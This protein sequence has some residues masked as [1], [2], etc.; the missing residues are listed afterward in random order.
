M[1]QL[2][3]HTARRTV[4]EA[5][6]RQI[7]ESPVRTSVLLLAFFGILFLHGPVVLLHPGLWGEDGWLWYPDAY[8]YGIKSLL[9]PDG[10]YLNTLSR[11]TA[12]VVQP[13]PLVY[14]PFLFASL[15]LLI[16][17]ITAAFIVS[18]RMALAWP[19]ALGRLSF[20]LIYLVLPNSWEIFGNLTDAQWH[21][22]ILSFLI[23]TSEGPK[24]IRQ[25][26]FDCIVLLLSG[27]SGPFCILLIPI[28]IWK[29][30]EI[31]KSFTA[32]RLAVVSFCSFVQLFFLFTHPSARLLAPLG[33]SVT[34]LARIMAAQIFFGSIFGM[35]SINVLISSDVWKFDVTPILICLGGIS[36]GIVAFWRGPTLLRKATVFS[37]LSFFSALTAPLVSAT[38]PQWPLMAMPLAGDRYYVF[39]IL[40]WCGALFVLTQDRSAVLRSIGRL[41][42]S[43][44]V[45][46]GIPVDH[47]YPYIAKTNFR[48]HAEAFERAPAG[49]RIVF[50]TRPDGYMVL[51]KK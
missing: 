17:A 29:L 44:M 35:R 40:A 22:A 7:A 24:N 38:S 51:N 12:F 25:V 43:I 39:P 8:Q 18:N 30:F 4:L 37:S 48:Q 19:S 10:G 32:L 16:Q 46:L 26:T 41:L 34:G 14:V 11:L 13:A 5:Q 50:P 42:L 2:N 36:L 33:A 49:T 15:A 6:A 27:V 28:A 45:L 21:L 1:H 3:I 9:W 20:A 23:L 31:E 47:T